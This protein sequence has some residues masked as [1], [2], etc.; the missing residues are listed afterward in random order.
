[1]L[2]VKDLGFSFKHS[3]L[4]E[5]LSFQLKPGEI[6]HLTGPNGA[7]K[8]TC[9]SVLSGLREPSSGSVA[10]QNNTEDVD[11]RRRYIEYLSAEANGLYLKMD[12]FDNL[13]FWTRLRGLQIGES[14]IMQ[15]LKTWGLGHRLVCRDFPVEKFSTGMRR[16]LALAR[17]NLSEAPCWLLDEPIYG[18]DKKGI[19]LFREMLINH[20][21]KNGMAL[22]ISHD[23]DPLVDLSDQ[24][25]ELAKLKD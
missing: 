11:D 3:L 4:F 15:E 18:L 6:I 10:F 25:I 13:R 19:E 22:V 1:M 12:A 8:S 23:T 21:K 17:V 5:N 20:K 7:G 2:T 16:R 9:F 24:T 14:Q